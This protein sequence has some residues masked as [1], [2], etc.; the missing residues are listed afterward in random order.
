[1]NDI[2]DKYAQFGLTEEVRQRL[3]QLSAL[4][5]PT[6]V[7]TPLLIVETVIIQGG[8]R[9]IVSKEEQGG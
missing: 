5:P 9:T 2:E 6:D 7:A 4:R 8:N 3:V 1:M